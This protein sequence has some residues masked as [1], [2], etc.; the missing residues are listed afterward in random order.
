MDA[1]N[2]WV[3]QP[4]ERKGDYFF[5]GTLY[6]TKNLSR[7]IS[8]EEI[9]WIIS[10]L[11]TLVQKEQGIDYFVVYIRPDGRKVFCIDQHSKSMMESGEYTED[12]IKE[13]NHWTILFA[14][15][16]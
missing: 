9:I 2:I 15:E 14:E 1:K 11:K 5:N 4:Q 8:Q 6:L 3:R 10:D 7:Q 16:Y 13:Y 12:E